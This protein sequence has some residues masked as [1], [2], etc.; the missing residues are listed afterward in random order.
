MRQYRGLT[1]EGKWVYG[2][3]IKLGSH[4]LIYDETSDW[5]NAGEAGV[6]EIEGLTEV[7]PETVGQQVGLK[8]KNGKE[9]Y[10]GDIV[11]IENYEGG[12]TNWLIDWRELS[13]QRIELPWDSENEPAN[14]YE[15]GADWQQYEIIGNNHQHPKLMEVKK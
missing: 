8:D 10:E 9:I 2:W 14:A 4:H 12:F 1:K 11:K 7:I 6:I 3:Y 5:D 13:W 15:I